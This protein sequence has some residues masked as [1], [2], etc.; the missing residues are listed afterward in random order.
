M[1]TWS[2]DCS[3][4]VFQHR[5]NHVS[6]SHKTLHQ[7]P[8][9]VKILVFV[10]FKRVRRSELSVV[11]KCW[12]AT[13]SHFDWVADPFRRQF[14]YFWKKGQ[15][16]YSENVMQE[17]VKLIHT[18][19]HSFCF[20]LY[21]CAALFVFPEDL[22]P[23]LPHRQDAEGRCVSTRHQRAPAG[24]ALCVCTGTYTHSG[25]WRL[26][27]DTK[28]AVLPRRTCAFKLQIA[29][30][31]ALFSCARSH[32][33][34]DP[35]NHAAQ[36]SACTFFQMKWYSNGKSFCDLNLRVY[37]TYLFINYSCQC[38]FVRSQFCTFVSTNSVPRTAFQLWDSVRELPYKNTLVKESVKE[39][40]GGG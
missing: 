2:C 22:N 24:C 14:S 19:T 6:A 30:F 33:N 7:R 4:D 40:K 15:K 36:P 8:Y 21:F 18:H 26:H 10:A 28:V 39:R 31:G 35:I 29:A 20:P 23:N 32:H 5:G 25:S 3:Q 1:V 17:T 37:W 12:I 13:L 16:I 11:L 27:P 38:H 9:Y 34:C